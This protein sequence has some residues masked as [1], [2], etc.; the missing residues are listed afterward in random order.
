M[1]KISLLLTGIA[2]FSLIAS[3]Q[4][5][6]GSIW[7]GGNIGFSTSKEEGGIDSKH[8]S[9]SISPAIGTAIKE[10]TI[11]GVQ[12]NFSQYKNENLNGEQVVQYMGADLFERKYWS[13]LN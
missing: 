3:A 10:N 1:K 2:F 12:F 13:L 6:K 8:S 11:L 7:L 9:Y 5:P 4:I